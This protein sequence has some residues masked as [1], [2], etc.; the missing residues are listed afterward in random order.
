MKKQYNS[1]AFTPEESK[2]AAEL[3]NTLMRFN[4]LS[5]EHYNDIHVTTDGYCTIIE[6]VCVPYSHE[7]GGKFDY[8]DEEHYPLYAY[9]MPSGI[10]EYFAN[11]HEY[12]LALI[13]FLRKNPD[14]YWDNNAWKWKSK[15]PS[16][17]EVSDWLKRQK[18]I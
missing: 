14:Y 5:K 6:W 3:L 11:E 13:E 15:E 2:A 9:E 16:D 4:T 12:E 17:D 10:T 7:W 1:M 8:I 18:S